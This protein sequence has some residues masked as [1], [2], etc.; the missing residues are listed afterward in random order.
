MRALHIFLVR[1][2]TIAGV[3]LVIQIALLIGLHY[4]QHSPNYLNTLYTLLLSRNGMIV[5]A[6]LAGIL[7]VSLAFLQIPG[8]RR[9][10]RTQTRRGPTRGSRGFRRSGRGS[11][12]DR[13]LEIARRHS[14]RERSPEW[15][16]V[17]HEHLA[18]EPACVACGYRGKGL[19][20]HHIKPFHLHPQLELDPNNLMTLCEIPGRDHHLLIGHLDNFESYNPHVRE[21]TRK[22]YG[23]TADQIRAAPSWKKEVLARP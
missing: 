8:L 6:T 14:G 18:H 17:E 7:V 12:H 20:V 3:L 5:L 15:S 11:R 19:Q 10:R 13:G 9:V 22:Y 23:K 4:Y 21:D 2:A 16:R 1:V